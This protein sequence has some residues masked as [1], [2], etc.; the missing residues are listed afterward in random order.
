MSDRESREI[1]DKEFEAVRAT[2][3]LKRYQHFVSQVADWGRIYTLG[4]DEEIALVESQEAGITYACAWPHRRYAEAERERDWQ[5]YRVLDFPLQE[6]LDRLLPALANDGVEVGVF[7]VW[8]H[9]SW[10]MKADELR[11]ELLTALEQY[12]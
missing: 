2:D 9:G 1:P 6:W 8:D 12:G 3:S 5:R 11:Q 10:T 4:D 7:P